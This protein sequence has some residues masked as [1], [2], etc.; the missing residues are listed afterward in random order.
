[1]MSLRH[2][3]VATLSALLLMGAAIPAGAQASAP[4]GGLVAIGG[5]FGGAIPTA[6]RLDNGFYAGGGV[7]V[8]MASHV[9]LSAE[10]GAD[11][12]AIDR[13]GFRSN[14]MPRFADVGV[15]VH[16]RSDP[17]RPFITG[18]V[19]IYRHTINVSSEAFSDPILRDQ[20][21]ARGLT[22]SSRGSIQVRHDEPGINL[23]GGFDYF[24]TR[25]SA[26]TMDVRAHATRNFVEVAPFGGVFV[27][28]AIGFRQYF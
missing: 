4:Y 9:S 14:L 25:R 27:N 6:D 11:H 20:L 3:Q 18:G 23:G 17:F 7:L 5:A 10:A 28:L 24:F 16:W 19:G 26:L 2:L 12:V 8:A 22:P 1:M 13:P 21:V 15:L